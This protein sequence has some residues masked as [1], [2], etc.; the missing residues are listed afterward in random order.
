MLED[1][2]ALK[3]VV[4]ERS[5]DCRYLGQSYEIDVPYRKSRSLGRSFLELFHRRHQ[6]LYS[7]RH[8]RRPVEIVNVRVKAVAVTPKL[9]LVREPRAAGLDPKALVK[10]QKIHTAAG[11]C[12]RARS[13]TGPG[14]TPGIPF[15]RPG[16]PHR[17]RIDDLPAARHRAAASTATST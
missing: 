3:D 16:P 4:L 11:P 6:Q 13:T 15:M 5:L 17:L 9:P 2:F 12:L 10:R 1:G 8:D 7:Y 14:F